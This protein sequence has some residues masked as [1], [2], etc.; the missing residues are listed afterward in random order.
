MGAAG[1]RR[2]RRS[3]RLDPQGGIAGDMFVAAMVDTLPELDAVIAPTIAALRKT[4][5]LSAKI[6][7]FHDGLFGG[8]QLH[9]D[10]PDEHAHRDWQTI[11]RLLNGSDLTPAVRERACAIFE[12]LAEAEAAIHNTG[13]DEV[14]FHEIGAWDSIVDITLAAALIEASGIDQWQVSAIPL[15]SGQIATRH[16]VVSVPAPATVRLLIGLP[17][18]DDGIAGERVT[19]TGAAIIRHLVT[20]TKPRLQG[21]LVA[22]G[23]GFGKRRLKGCSNCLRISVLETETPIHSIEPMIEIAFE[24][25]DMTPEALAVGLDHLRQ[26][27][28]VRDVF[29]LPATGKKG[30]QCQAV[31]VTADAKARRQIID[32]AFI[33]TSTLGLRVRP[34]ERHLLPR[35]LTTTEN[36]I[37]VKRTER[38]GGLTTLKTDIDD[39]ADHSDHASRQARA[40]AAEREVAG[41]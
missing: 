26:L 23:A 27:T 31:R 32:A 24:V 13:I 1:N 34:V 20:D 12:L 41:S 37:R 10:L 16:G 38:P 19:P 29:L 9:L 14:T 35:E 15:G 3:V 28:G 8:R 7:P 2:L 5:R 17:M 30:R 18:I 11:R 4:A 36:G 6:E 22:H 21:R 33:Q 39:V 40:Q 25:D